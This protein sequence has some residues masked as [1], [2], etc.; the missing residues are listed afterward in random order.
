MR[1]SSLFLCLLGVAAGAQGA[2][3]T[4]TDQVTDSGFLDGT[5]FTNALVTITFQ[6]DTNNVTSS[7][8]VFSV[9]G[10]AAVN[11]AGLTPDTLTGTLSAYS[12]NMFESGGIETATSVVLATDNAA[13]ATYE[14]N[15]S[16]GPLVGQAFVAN[17]SDLPT[18]GGTF[19]L[20][21]T[22][23][24]LTFTATVAGSPV[25]EPGSML[26]LGA[27]IAGLMLRRR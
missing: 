9:V 24:Q 6:G 3:I 13:F 8:A 25:P 11:V 2:L 10:T 19:G 26:L 17:P 16:L 27:G 14:L 12:D 5:P 18:M 20:D 21:A 22:M 7:F 1:T 4:V 15:T 23:N